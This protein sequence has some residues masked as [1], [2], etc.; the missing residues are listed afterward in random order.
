MREPLT[1]ERLADLHRM[2]AEIVRQPAS[3]WRM[4]YQEDIVDAVDEIDRLTE[5]AR[6]AA[7]YIGDESAGSMEFWRAYEPGLHGSDD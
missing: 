6:L 3:D 2:R 1:D 7:E 4:S 5:V